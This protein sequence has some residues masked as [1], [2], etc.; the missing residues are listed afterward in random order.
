[1]HFCPTVA[2]YNRHIGIDK[3]RMAGLDVRS[4]A[5]N[6]SAVHA[7]QTPF[8]HGLFAVAWVVNAPHRE[9]MGAPLEGN[10]FFNAP[11]QLV[12]WDIKLEWQGLYAIFDT[13]FAQEYLHVNAPS[14]EWAC[15]YDAVS[16]PLVLPADEMPWLSL[17]FKRLHEEAIKPTGDP[18]LAGALLHALLDLVVRYYQKPGEQS[19]DNHKARLVNE[20]RSIARRSIATGRGRVSPTEVAATLRVSTGHLNALVREVTNG[21]TTRDL[22]AIE[23]LIESQRL[24]RRTDL[25]IQEI[26]DRLGYSAAT[27][28]NNFF[29]KAT[30]QSAGAWRTAQRRSVP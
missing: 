27:H 5:E 3:P 22:L 18:M 29:R 17:T 15:F 26:A 6:M 10:V 11:Y 24:L 12:S 30:G 4:F 20:V 14:D 25:Q 21:Q 13:A 7:R 2:A 8:R 28:F 19:P 1:M 23:V 16:Q 9:V